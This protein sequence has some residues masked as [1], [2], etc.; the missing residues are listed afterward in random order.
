MKEPDEFIATWHLAANKQESELTDFEFLLW[1]VFYGFLNWQEN[2]QNCIDEKNELNAY[3]LCIL[4]IIRMNDRPKNVYELCN[5]LNRN[6]VPN[7]LYIIRKLVKLG[8]VKKHKGG[9]KKVLAYQV[10]EAGIK[11]TDAYTQAR[12]NILLKMLENE[13]PKLDLV[14][15]TK[16]L[17]LIKGIY[18]EAGRIAA[19][20]KGSNNEI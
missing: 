18:D 14:Q 6:D 11:N 8:F 12:K 20:Y 5:L 19:S 16:T 4:H 9:P 13:N 1:R 3:D 15:T 10:T 2:C 17:A 7:V